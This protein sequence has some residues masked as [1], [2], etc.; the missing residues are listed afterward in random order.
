MNKEQMRQSDIGAEPL[1]TQGEDEYRMHGPLN[2]LTPEEFLEW[3]NSQPE[4]ED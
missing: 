2:P 4:L 3:L 1:T